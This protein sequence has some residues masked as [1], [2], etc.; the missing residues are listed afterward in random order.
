MFTSCKSKGKG[1]GHPCT[2]TEALYRPYVPYGSRGIALPFHDHGTRRGWGVCATH[3]PIFTPG[4]DPVPILQETEWAPG[5]VWV[6]VENVAPTGIRSPARSQSL[7][8]LRYQAHTMSNSQSLYRLRY[9]AHVYFMYHQIFYTFPQ[10]VVTCFV[11]FY[12]QIV[13]IPHKGLTS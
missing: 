3:R 10:T 11:W 6:G 8:R 13:I 9:P 12:K 5:P 1:K 2:G 4:K 7:Y